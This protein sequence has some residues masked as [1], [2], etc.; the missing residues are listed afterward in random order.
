MMTDEVSEQTFCLINGSFFPEDAKQVLMTLV[1][2]KINFHQRS[3]WGRIERFGEIDPS[4][5][6]RIEELRQTKVDITALIDNAA[7]L[8]M[9]LSIQCNIEILLEPQ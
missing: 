8:G 7:A 4:S 2:D 6:R 1:D 9:K 3:D 5:A